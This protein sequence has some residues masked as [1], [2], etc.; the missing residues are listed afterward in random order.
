MKI[1]YCVNT[2]AFWGG[3]EMVTVAKANALA[4]NPDN[5][6]WIVTCCDDS[7]RTCAP[8]SDKV[9]IVGMKNE[10]SKGFPWNILQWFL[11]KKTIKTG[12]RKILSE[13]NPDV[14]ISTG[15]F[16]KW[17]VPSVKGDWARIRE[18]HFIKNYREKESGPI[19]V[20][21]A[22]F[23]A[24]QIDYH[25]SIKRFDRIVVLTKEDKRVN[26]NDDDKVSVIPNPV[27]FEQ[28]RFSSLDA[29][30]I[31]AVGRLT[32]SKNFQSLLR[33]FSAVKARFPEWMLD[34]YGEGEDRDSLLA[35]MDS[36][37]LSSS[38]RLMGNTAD[39]QERLPDYSVSVCSSL[40]EG[41]GMAIVEAMSC[42]I[43]VVSYDCPFGPGEIIT[44]GLDGFL[45][46]VGDESAM[47]ERICRLIDDENLRKSM[48]SSAARRSVDFNIGSICGQWETLFHQMR[49]R[50]R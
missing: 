7:H 37:G 27:R 22:A 9:G 15:G 38:V 40:H 30:S 25:F 28:G 17:I 21:M 46:P 50:S 23:F 34:I 24:E 20:R 2:L 8:V 36:L 5:S 41:F 14:L 16:D 32:H 42:G 29:K 31:V 1:V 43:P 44:D 39:I 6:V 48:G 12:L 4:R 33:V 45:V 47:A 11:K 3:L 19:G 49:D 35:R 26:W 10:L 13:I 18:I